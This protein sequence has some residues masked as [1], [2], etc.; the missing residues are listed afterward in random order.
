[1][2]LTNTIRKRFEN[3]L[4]G[5]YAPNATFSISTGRF[6]LYDKEN[7]QLENNF[8]STSERK[9]QVSCGQQSY[10][11]P[12]NHLDGFALYEMPVNIKVSY[13][14]TNGGNEDTE[15]SSE[16]AGSG[17]YD[18]IL[19]RAMTDFHDISRTVTW[20]E[21]YGSLSPSVYMVTLEAHRVTASGRKIISD[22]QFKVLYQASVTTSY[23]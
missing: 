20:Y 21:N 17:L 10:T 16:E 11:V 4:L 14:N 9:F 3:L 8:D 23:L 13:Y 12:L 19:D 2:S 15:G 6:L 5:S 7:G 18:E 22:I 1:M